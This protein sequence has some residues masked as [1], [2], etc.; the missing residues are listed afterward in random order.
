MEQGIL[1]ILNK[2]GE[3]ESRLK[4]VEVLLNNHLTHSQ[5]L[6]FILVGVLASITSAV[7][8]KF[9]FKKRKV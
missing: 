3:I 5:Q 4:V 8:I 7:V 1:E 6:V 9:I 2:L